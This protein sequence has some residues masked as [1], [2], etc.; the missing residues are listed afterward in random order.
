MLEPMLAKEFNLKWLD[1]DYALQPKLNGHRLIWDGKELWSRTGKK[2]VSVPGLVCELEKFF[3]DFPMDGELFAPTMSF[4][5]ITEVG[6]RTVNITDDLNICMYVYDAPIK[7]LSF[8]DRYKLIQQAIEFHHFTTISRI[9]IV[10]TLFAKKSKTK[11][12]DPKSLNI[13]CDKYEGTMVR[14]ANSL[15]KFGKRSSDL[16][17]IKK[18]YDTEAVIVGVTQFLSKE[19][20]LV[21]KGTPGSKKYAD[22]TYYKDGVKT[23][24]DMLG[25]FI[26]KLPNGVEFELGTGLTHEERKAFWKKPPIGAKVTF[27]YQEF[28]EKGVPLFPSYL[29]IREDI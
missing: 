5:E 13:Y 23:P 16:M 14:N 22:G 10:K 3:G 9:Q 24:Q 26:C 8:I 17:K 27:Q 18:F 4:K 29:R 7:N 2:I 11:K 28:T 19:K 25:S 6:R 21:S 20:V 12:L 1:E 15:Y